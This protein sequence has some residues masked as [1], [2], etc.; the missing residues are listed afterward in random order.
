MG[1]F[2]MTRVKKSS[3]VL[4][5]AAVLLGGLPTAASGQQ[6]LRENASLA[7]LRFIGVENEGTEVAALLT[8]DDAALLAATREPQTL[9]YLISGGLP[10]RSSRLQ[11]LIDWGLLRQSGVAF[12][13]HI[14]I[15]TDGAAE[16]LAQLVGA[17][18]PS[19]AADID[20]S[21]Q[22]LSD[23]LWRHPGVPSLPAVTAWMLRD[24]VWEHLSGAHGLDF[25]ARLVEQRLAYP[26]R[27]FW[28]ALWYTETP[29]PPAY[30]LQE[31]RRDEYTVHLAWNY[32]AGDPFFGA[33]DG[34]IP[35]P[36]LLAKLDDRGRRLDDREDFPGALAAG[37]VD[38][39]GNMRILAADYRL[40]D[41]ESLAYA[42][43]ETAVAVTE[44]FLR[45]VPIGDL[46][47]LLGSSREIAAIIAY[48][49]LAPRLVAELH[50]RGQLVR[51]DDPAAEW[52]VTMET[53]DVG[54]PPQRATVMGG[55]GQP[56]NPSPPFAAMIWRDLPPRPQLRIVWW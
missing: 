56:S 8:L 50:A 30:D 53:S 49:E 47:A 7:N 41:E 28:G 13:S 34:E 18:A 25:A 20:A 46:A 11:Q 45:H 2:T 37:L 40:D 12:Q 36:Q 24:R 21:L 51:A 16:R 17:S 39:S 10:V 31:W 3:T 1:S 38:E 9:N 22:M 42:I 44:A 35:M 52:R 54:G 55:D 15:V 14:P 29:A 5:C 33:P 4:L 43:E 19:V 23:R 26:D 6:S 27:G 32:G 48:T